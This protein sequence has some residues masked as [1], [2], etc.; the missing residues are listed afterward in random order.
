M[1]GGSLFVGAI[2]EPP[3]PIRR[4]GDNMVDRFIVAAW[5][6]FRIRQGSSSP[7]VCIEI[8]GLRAVREPPLRMHHKI[9]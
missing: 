9:R 4:R 7:I 5:N 1:I 8:R 6:A 3:A 2:R